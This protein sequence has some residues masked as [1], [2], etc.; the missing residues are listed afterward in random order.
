VSRA[1]AWNWLES[2][3]VI[4]A[5]VGKLRRKIA[6][7]IASMRTGTLLVHHDAEAKEMS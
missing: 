3:M 6:S 1:T 7:L 2:S 4:H 5:N